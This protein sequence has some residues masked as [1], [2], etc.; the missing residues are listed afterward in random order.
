MVIVRE[1]FA[2]NFSSDFVKRF[3]FLKTLEEKNDQL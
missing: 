3:F 1:F 2:L